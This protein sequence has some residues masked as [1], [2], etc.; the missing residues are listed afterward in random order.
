[1]TIEEILNELKKANP[2][3][4]VFFDF[5]RAVPM[6]VH[7]WSGVYSEPT[8]G[9]SPSGYG[10]S[11]KLKTP[12][13]RDFQKELLEAISGKEYHG[14]KG[15]SFYFNADQELHVGNR[16]DCNNTIIDHIEIHPRYVILHTKNK[17]Y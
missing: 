11:P 13:V 14:W 10:S 5:R 6:S 15:G 8:I 16:G 2:Q 9:W 7:S 12:L 17:G 3:A 1:M 4:D